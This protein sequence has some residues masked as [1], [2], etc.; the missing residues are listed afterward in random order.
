[1]KNRKLIIAGLIALLVVIFGLNIYI[2]LPRA[3]KEINQKTISITVID[4]AKNVDKTYTIKTSQDTLLGAL[5]PL[6]IVSGVETDNSYTITTVNSIE[7]DSSSGQ[8]WQ[9][10]VNG[11]ET[12]TSINNIEIQNNDHV[13]FDL[14]NN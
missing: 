9:V 12:K 3:I 5:K 14:I 2:S 13:E 8:V 4:T 6:G 1:M 11:T 10:S 7:A